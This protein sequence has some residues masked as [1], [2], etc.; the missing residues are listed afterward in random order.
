MSIKNKLNRL[1]PQLSHK[2]G[3]EKLV[4][5]ADVT[6]FPYREV[7]EKAGVFP[8]YFD[9]DF[10]LIRE[11]EYSISEKH[12]IYT[13]AQFYQ[14]VEA[15]N[16]AEISHPLSAAGFQSDQF[17]FFDTETTGLGGGVGNTIFI[18]GHAS[19][20]GNKV[21]LKQH[22]LPHPGAEV[23]LYKSFLDSINYK[24]MATYNGKSFDWPQV[25][26]R[27]TL[28]RDQ[29]P[30][31]P[32]FGHFDLYHASRRMWKH[33]LERIKLS[34]VEKEVLGVER[35]DDLPGFLAP[36]IYFDY[37]ET[38][39]PE[40]MLAVLKHNEL[41]ILSLISLYTHLSFQILGI[42]KGQ[43]AREKYEVGRWF[44]QLGE[45]V[46]AKKA[47]SNISAGNGAEALQAKHALAFEYKK[48]K[49]WLEAIQLWK[50]VAEH[51]ELEIKLDACIEL[52]KIF[53]HREKNIE[54][55]LK[56]TEMAESIYRANKVENSSV[57][58][59]DLTKRLQRLMRK[60]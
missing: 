48:Q 36:M 18:L 29:V 45:T 57:K 58:H 2:T 13:F 38:K 33:K 52:A 14:A 9:G 10:C 1:K 26:T 55:A 49:N 39:N 7:W 43:T 60:K 40:G 47:F 42:D 4:P 44:S 22:I 41:D 27:H 20:Q 28:I 35:K 11:K 21:H 16:S 25:K 53:E 8:F 6:D 23:P 32:P 3:S 24:M 54:Q 12:G 34:V 17:F 5:K 50:D 19:L 31:L 15:W 51:S 46:S 30:K 37:V 56:Y 59:E